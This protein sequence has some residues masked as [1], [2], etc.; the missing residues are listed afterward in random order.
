MAIDTKQSEEHSTS[1]LFYM[2]H[3]CMKD[4]NMRYVAGPTNFTFQETKWPI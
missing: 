1:L 3:N 2:T 4:E